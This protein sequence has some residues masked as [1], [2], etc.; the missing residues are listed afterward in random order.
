MFIGDRKLVN[1]QNPEVL[2]RAHKRALKLRRPICDIV[3]HVR[4]SRKLLL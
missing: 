2:R 1:D 4:I 3:F